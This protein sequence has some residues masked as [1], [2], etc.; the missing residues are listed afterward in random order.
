VECAINAKENNLLDTPGWKQFKNI[1]EHEQ[2]MFQ[3]LNQSNLR[4][5]D[6]Y[7]G[8][9]DLCKGEQPARYSRLEAIQENSKT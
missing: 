1:A 3:E 2:R 6:Y 8:V 4:E 9:C 7:R 5:V